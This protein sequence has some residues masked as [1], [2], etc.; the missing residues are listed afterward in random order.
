MLKKRPLP[1]FENRIHN[2]CTLHT[3]HYLKF[4]VWQCTFISC[5]VLKFTCDIA[6]FDFI[7]CLKKGILL[8]SKLNT[9]HQF[10]SMIADMY[11]PK[12]ICFSFVSS[13]RMVS[14]WR[15]TGVE[16]V[17]KK[18]PASEDKFKCVIFLFLTHLTLSAWGPSLYVWI[19]RLQS[20][21]YDVLLYMYYQ[22]GR[23][24]GWQDLKP[25]FPT[26]KNHL[27]VLS[28]ILT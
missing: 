27:V 10:Q 9:N 15:V 20:S 1:R 12:I 19:W 21:Y 5:Q 6:K 3:L 25:G 23:K 16:S 26:E 14:T 11:F 17:N 13:S 28:K 8:V 18:Y 2:H 24:Y 22:L 7:F 4:K